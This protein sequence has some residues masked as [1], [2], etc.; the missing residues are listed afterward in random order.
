VHLA[1]GESHTMSATI[2]LPKPKLKPQD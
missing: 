1:P 2:S